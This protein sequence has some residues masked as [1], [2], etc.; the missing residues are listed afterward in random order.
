MRR[1]GGRGRGLTVTDVILV[2]AGLGFGGVAGCLAIGAEASAVLARASV[3][4][5]MVWLGVVLLGVGILVTLLG[6]A[7]SGIHA[8][9]V[10][11]AKAWAR[12][13]A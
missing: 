9:L 6:V 3:L 11:Q 10:E 1:G 4:T 13:R 8:S 5:F 12:L 2:V 7:V